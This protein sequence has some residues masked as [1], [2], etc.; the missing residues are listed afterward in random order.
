MS[1]VWI[2]RSVK[3]LEDPKIL[4]G[5]G[6]YV[7]DIQLPG[8][9]F[10]SFVRSQHA[11]AE[12]TGVDLSALDGLEGVIGAYTYQDMAGLPP[13]PLLV[14]NA[15]LRPVTQYPLT[16]GTVRYVGEALAVVVG[17]S[18]YTAEDGAE[19]VEV[20]YNPLTP[21]TNARFGADPGMP[22]LHHSLENNLAAHI[23]QRIGNVEVAMKTAPIIIEE[24][25][26]IGRGA[27]H[28]MET[29]GVVA[30]YVGGRLTVWSSTQSPHSLRRALS[31]CLGMAEHQIHVVTP[32]VGG[33]FG[34]KAI[35]YPEEIVVPWLAMQL[36]T[37]VKWVEDRREHF[38]ATSH[39]RE[40]FHE[41]R[42]AV[43]EEG[44]IIA[45]EDSFWAD[46][47]AY[48]PWGII[49]PYLTSTTIPGPYK[50][51]NYSCDGYVV[52]TNKTPVAPY[53][54]AGRPQ[55][56][57]IM[58]R[59]MDRAAE[60]LG[61]DP[62]EIRLRNLVQED[63][64][65]YKVGL[66]YRDGSPLT[67][68]S[69]D[70]VTSLKSALA[71]ID[72][73]G[74]RKE[75]EVALQN[76]KYIG[77]GIAM[78][79]EGTGLGPFEGATVRVDTSGRVVVYTGSPAQGQG[80]KTVFAQ[81]VAE[82]L[83]IDM[84]LVDVIEG[85]TDHIARGI[86]TFASRVAAVGGSSVLQAAQEVRQQVAE[87][88]A[89]L[90]E[91]SSEDIEFKDGRVFPAGVPSRSA[92]FQDLALMANN[93]PPGSTQKKGVAPGLESTQ[94]FQP[95]GSTYSSG[96]HAATVEVDPEIGDIRILKYV[97]VHDCGKLLN[98]ML[99]DG[100]VQGGLGHGI[101]GAMYE[102]LVYDESGQLLT[103]S[104]MDYIM[105]TAHEIPNATIVHVETPSPLNPLG[106]K[107][108]GEGGTIPATAVLG[109]AVED[110]LRPFGVRISEYPLG[111]M[112]VRKALEEA[113][114]HA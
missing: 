87:L 26:Y 72:Y 23:K 18:A 113:K 10:A 81:I 95:K 44:H 35:V 67:Y 13:I 59:L 39:E 66:I 109:A 100:Q 45:V 32:D 65:P 24:K 36:R 8:M 83:G 34:P 94:Y 14:P 105:P 103:G 64:F 69:G 82:Q 37:P 47:G 78:Y 70:Y 104:Y 25:M 85:D 50:V 111:P 99:V 110:A 102:E 97:I 98:P 28:S 56:V 76:G 3:R 77:V 27:A 86:G 20:K 2:G 71:E 30:Q 114:Q 21:V 38:I 19:A 40:Q 84:H 63:E 4:S 92:S 57:T 96:V 12:I 88:A 108:A 91:A 29:R 79:V 33:G 89:N 74:F 68:D 52:Y 106:V 16:D 60:R 15:A 42:I 55:G 101:S 17:T 22:L 90:F 9:V 61:L 75:Q 43:D 112:K 58:E 49:V 80:H 46:Q 53:R 6:E 41:A 31:V 1:E 73:E 5:K 48:V 62:A 107:G 54:G 93:P 7:A 11:H 51:P